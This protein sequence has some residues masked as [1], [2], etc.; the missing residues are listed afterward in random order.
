MHRLNQTQIVATCTKVCQSNADKCYSHSSAY[1]NCLPIV[2][3]PLWHQALVE[4]GYRLATGTMD[5][6]R[7]AG[8]GLLEAL[9]AQHA[10]LEDPLLPGE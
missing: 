2:T 6:L 3:L 1:S 7:P 8:V 4:V 9:L 5:A 10:G